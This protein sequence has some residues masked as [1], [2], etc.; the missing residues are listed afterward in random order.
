MQLKTILYSFIPLTFFSCIFSGETNE[1]QT[2]AVPS[3]YDFRNGSGCG[4]FTVGD[5]IDREYAFKGSISLY[6]NPLDTLNEFTKINISEYSTD[7]E[8]FDVRLYY[9]PDSLFKN[10]SK[11]LPF[12]NDVILLTPHE[13]LEYVCDTGQIEYKI[14]KKE[15]FHVCELLLSNALFIHPSTKK[16]YYLK[17]AEIKDVIIGGR[18]G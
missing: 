17:G 4:Y 1:E 2:L 16:E 3:F 13:P 8:D 15:G 11:Q 6:K 12:C 18:P 7:I 5:F 14:S 9:F 10:V